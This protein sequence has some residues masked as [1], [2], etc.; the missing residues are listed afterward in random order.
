MID[1]SFFLNE[2][3]IEAQHSY[4]VGN[5]PI[6]ALLVDENGKIIARSQNLM[7]TK[8][9]YAFHAELELL[10]SCQEYLSKNQYSVALYSSLEPCFMC[11]GAAVISRILR[12]VWAANDYWAGFSNTYDLKSNYF[13]NRPLEL[14]PHP[15]KSLQE[16]SAALLFKY[17]NLN[18]PQ[19]VYSILGNQLDEK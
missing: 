6:G 14:I 18:D 10:L 16:Q 5:V 17:F 9:G 13:L 4:E 11:F 19:K 15:I 2:A 12:I 3:L 8:K 1:H 7:K